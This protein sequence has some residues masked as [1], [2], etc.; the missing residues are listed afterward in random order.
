MPWFIVLTSACALFSAQAKLS[1]KARLTTP[2]DDNLATEPERTLEALDQNADIA[3][4]DP[5]PQVKI[6]L[7]N[8]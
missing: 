1:K 2:T 6:L 3:L 5:V 8:R 7:L 4:D